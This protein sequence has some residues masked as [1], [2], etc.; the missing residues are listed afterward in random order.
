MVLCS[1]GHTLKHRTTAK[2]RN[3]MLTGHHIWCASCKSLID[4]GKG[5]YTCEKSCNWDLCS[6]C[7]DYMTGGTPQKP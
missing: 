1:S 7:F 2:Y 4:L 6:Q 3:I 5:Y